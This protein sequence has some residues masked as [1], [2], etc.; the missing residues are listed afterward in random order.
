VTRRV[1]V[2]FAE[3]NCESAIGAPDQFSVE[4]GFCKPGLIAH[5][6]QDGLSPRVES[7]SHAPHPTI[8]TKSQF[9]HV[10]VPGAFERVDARS[11]ELWSELC[12]KTGVGQQFG[13]DWFTQLAEL[14]HELDCQPDRP[15]H[16]RYL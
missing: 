11:A 8:G 16:E 15:G 5:G 14:I 1:Y 12:E 6:Q 3:V 13:L 7:E 9:L 10:R 2:H 4:A